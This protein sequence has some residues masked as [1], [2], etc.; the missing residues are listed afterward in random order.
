MKTNKA[1][2]TKEIL[3]LIGD[4]Y[5]ASYDASYWE[6]AMGKLCTLVQ[7]VS[8]GI[9]IKDHQ[10]KSSFSMYTYG[11]SKAVNFAYNHGMA[12][13][14]PSFN[15][16]ATKRIGI[17]PNLINLDVPDFPH[18]LYRQLVLIPA[19]VHY[20]AGVNLFNDNQWHVGIGLHRPKQAGAFDHETLD[21]INDLIPHF[22][23]AVKFR[24]EF[25]RLRTR[26]Q[27]LEARP[28]HEK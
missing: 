23:R 21:L 24:R 28:T 1:Q 9:Y 26:N 13:L 7:A 5:D 18:P 3:S 6:V 17:E 22:Q 15:I 20:A 4:I 14:D 11:L 16:M 27:T 12:N 19:G 10:Q 8:A 2:T 25:V